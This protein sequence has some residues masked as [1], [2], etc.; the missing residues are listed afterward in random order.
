MQNLRGLQCSS[1]FSANLP[2]EML[3]YARNAKFAIKSPTV[4]QPQPYN[5]PFRGRT[6]ALNLPC[7]A[8]WSWLVKSSKWSSAFR[9]HTYQPRTLRSR[10]AWLRFA[11]GL[12]GASRCNM[13]QLCN[14]KEAGDT[15]T[16]EVWITRTESDRMRQTI[17]NAIRHETENC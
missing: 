10:A 9:F 16:I 12:Q 11:S 3:R 1:W 6:S 7:C 13:S 14:N 5:F 15:S 4:F 2:L 17:P 8:R